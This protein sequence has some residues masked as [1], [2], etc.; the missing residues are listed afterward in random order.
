M[1]VTWYKGRQRLV[2]IKTSV[3]PLRNVMHATSGGL[4]W[5]WIV[6]TA[7]QGT[8]QSLAEMFEHVHGMYL[9]Q[10]IE[11]CITA[12]VAL[13]PSYS[14]RRAVSRNVSYLHTLLYTCTYTCQQELSRLLAIFLLARSMLPTA[15]QAV[16]FINSRY[17]RHLETPRQTQTGLLTTCLSHWGQRA[18]WWH[19][20]SS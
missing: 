16:L 10:S 13:V 8:Y 11:I 17:G 19:C 7:M 9:K 1:R 4:V 2:S 20:G 15:R 6:A 12:A 14:S 3:Q 18:L 5:M